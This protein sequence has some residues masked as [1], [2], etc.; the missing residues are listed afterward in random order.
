MSA[1]QASERRERIVGEFASEA[2]A[3]EARQKLLAGNL[4]PEQTYIEEQPLEP[5]IPFEGTQAGR[6]AKGGALAGGLFGGLFG[7]LLALAAE[8]FS[9]IEFARASDAV[10]LALGLALAGGLLGTAAFSLMGALSGAN[11][12]KDFDVGKAASPPEKQYFVVLQGTEP[13][14]QQALDILQQ[15]EVPQE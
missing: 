9:A 1:Q 5:S 6:G 12:P 15:R 13:E 10:L 14:L 11:A 4:A 2:A 8:K 7:L 3:R